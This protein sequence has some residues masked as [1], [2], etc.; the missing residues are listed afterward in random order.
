MAVTDRGAPFGSSPL[1]L[2]GAQRTVLD[3]RCNGDQAT[4]VQGAG[5]V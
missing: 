2:T 1:N 5:E 3:D 4:V